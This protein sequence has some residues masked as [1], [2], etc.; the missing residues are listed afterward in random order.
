MASSTTIYTVSYISIVKLMV[1]YGTNLI[2]TTVYFEWPCQYVYIMVLYGFVQ[3]E[4]WSC[5][6]WRDLEVNRGYLY[7]VQ[8]C[9]IS[10][11]NLCKYTHTHNVD[12]RVKLPLYIYPGQS[13]SNVISIY[14]CMFRH[15]LYRIEL[16]CVAEQ[17]PWESYISLVIS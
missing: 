3:L 4:L 7:I 2:Y 16:N 13:W 17:K 9:V 5:E 10:G 6:Q 1:L 15:V 8:V 11:N 14:M 12:V